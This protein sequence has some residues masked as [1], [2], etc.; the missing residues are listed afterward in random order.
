MRNHNAPEGLF[1]TKGYRNFVELCKELPPIVMEVVHRME[2]NGWKYDDDVFMAILTRKTESIEEQMKYL[3]LDAV[4][5]VEARRLY[6][7]IVYANRAIEKKWM[8]PIAAIPEKINQSDKNMEI[9]I[10]KVE[11]LYCQASFNMIQ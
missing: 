7:R 5:D 9:F 6:Y 2:A 1:H 3:F 8:Q 4:D 11:N 10:I